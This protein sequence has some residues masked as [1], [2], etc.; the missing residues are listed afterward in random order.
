[1]DTLS[2]VQLESYRISNLSFELLQDF[3]EY[4]LSKA[5]FQFDVDYNVF[6]LENEKFLFRVSVLI[7]IYPSENQ[8][9][10][11]PYDL[12]L[13]VEGLFR[14]DSE[15]EEDEI[16]YHLHNS[17]PTMLYGIA[18]GIVNNITSQGFYGSVLLPSVQFS[19]IGEQKFN[20]QK[21]KDELNSKE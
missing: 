16:G 11:L 20:A 6:L 12:E 10:F 21:D 17:C 5:S 15:T 8:D 18:R 2:P 9:F 4:D 7:D 3:E 14:F 1:M 19:K 13:E